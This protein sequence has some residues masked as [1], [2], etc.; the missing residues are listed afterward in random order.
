MDGQSEV[1]PLRAALDAT[2]LARLETMERVKALHIRTPRDDATERGVAFLVETATTRSDPKAPPGPG[3]RREGR[4]LLVTGES[5][6]GK[7]TILDRA[8][9]THPAF[10]GFRVPG[11]GC[12]LVSVEVPGSCTLM[13][14]GREL[15]ATLGYPLAA[16]RSEGEVWEQA[17]MRLEMFDVRL[18]HFDEAHNVIR[19]ADVKQSAKIQK[20]LKALLNSPTHPVSLILSGL[21]ELTLFLESLTENRRR[22]VFLRLEPLTP[23]DLPPL[24]AAMAS[25]AA[26]G[27]L[28][29]ST[30]ALEAIAPRLS[31]TA[32]H[33]LGSAIEIV[34]GAIE[35]ALLRGAN[36]LT[37]EDFAAFYAFRTGNGAAMNPFLAPD[38]A[39]VDCTRA[40]RRGAPTPPLE[41][42]TP[43]P[44]RRQQ[45]RR[46]ASSEDDRG[47]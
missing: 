8:F 11:S 31:H 34:H 18:I 47:F 25:L 27:G 35:E 23:T 10:A 2:T 30:E 43:A 22:A 32:L 20:T 4:A 12:P 26:A 21:P 13:Q 16:R 5:G 3:N 7:S 46:K 33:Q 17:R 44:R 6:A 38:W 14:L 28:S 36:A 37:I 42:A 45:P 19:G 41:I 1:D 29:A 15:L 40:L 39:A 24:R 9:R